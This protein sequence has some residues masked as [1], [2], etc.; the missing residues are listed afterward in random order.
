M[1][2]KIFY[3]MTLLAVGT[4]GLTSCTGEYE[5]PPVNLPDGGIGTGAWDNPM[6]AY[7]CL[8]GS[9]N[10]ERN[11][12]WVTGYIVGVINTEVGTVLNER[13]AQFDGPFGVNTNLMIS[14]SPDILELDPEDEG[15]ATRW[16]K[17]AS[18]QLPSGSVR[19]ALNLV[20]HPENLGKL[21]TIK[22]TTGTKYCGVYGLRS[23][24][25]YNWGDKGVE[26]VE[27]APIEGPFYQ[28]FE[29]STSF[30]VY[31]RQG[32]K[33]VKVLG[34]LSGWYLR[35]FDNNTY[36]TV[37]AYNGTATGGP[38]ENW[39]ISPAIELDKLEKKTLEFITQAAYAA[40]NST[41]EVY[42]MT[43]NTPSLSTN[44]KLPA[45]IATPPGSGGATY[46]SWV[47]SG[48]LDLSQFSGTIY[49]GWRYYSEHGGQD[50]SSTYCVDNVS[51]GGATEA[52]IPSTPQ[53]P[54]PSDGA[55]F[56]MLD[57]S[58]SS[59]DWTF[60]NVKLSGDL[61]YVWAWKE[62][63]GS[64]YLN[65]SAFFSNQNL[66]SEAYAYSPVISLAGVTGAYVEFEHAAKFQTTIVNL[67]K[68]V[69]R[70]KGSTSWTELDIPNWPAAGNWNFA[71]SGKINI[72]A[73]D[74]KE[75][76]VGF[77]YASTTAGAD[78][79]EIKNLKVYGNK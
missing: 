52:D 48:V 63:N 66:V 27:L 40:D 77:K 68:F 17:C 73:F 61:S 32:W 69:I 10:P 74:G 18:V 13:S 37:S 53:P 46:S 64:H 50:G 49:I 23:A 2:K 75:V 8:I 72:G 65:G 47:E 26:E 44:T 41:L 11:E 59:I 20:D 45:A 76:E 56:S 54:T 1:I 4:L 29:A 51:V 14:M 19:S 39:L 30:D 35:S 79:W 28:N 24:S 7:Q 43:S 6:T 16:E 12:V 15:Y 58:A 55:L 57:A 70:E 36:I 67:G 34:G 22:G 60:D 25:N 71:S 21:V 38:Y 33:N 9:I 62:Y 42:A 5:Q 78:T 31:E 3:I